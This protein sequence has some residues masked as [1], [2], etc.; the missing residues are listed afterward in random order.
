MV[1][2]S[3]ILLEPEKAQNLAQDLNKV[4]GVE[5]LGQIFR[6]KGTEMW[7]KT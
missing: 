1:L 6:E 3:D 7:E 4:E 2:E 5:Y